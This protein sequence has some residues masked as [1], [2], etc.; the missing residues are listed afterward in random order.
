MGDNASYVVD[1]DQDAGRIRMFEA[2]LPPRLV[3]MRRHLKHLLMCSPMIVAA[4]VLIAT[5]AV[6]A[7]VLFPVAMCVLMM[8]AMM[9]LMMR[10]GGHSGGRQH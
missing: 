4:A 10:G 8:G 9:A 2:Q 5:G 1:P 7:A 6:G 3:R